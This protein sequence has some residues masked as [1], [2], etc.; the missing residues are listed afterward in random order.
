MN[1]FQTFSVN[2][3]P[4]FINSNQTLLEIIKYFNYNETLLIL[5]YNNVICP[6][7]YWNITRIQNDDTIEIIT[8]VGGG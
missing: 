3:N 1:T 2:G 6:K 5:E 8:I 4:Y 7:K